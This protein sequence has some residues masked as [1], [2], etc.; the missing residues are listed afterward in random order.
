[1]GDGWEL[2]G[3]AAASA[4]AIR[5]ETARLLVHAFRE[6]DLDAFMAYRNDRAWMRFQ[7]FKGLDVQAYRAALLGTRAVEKG[8]Q[9]AI[10]RRADGVLLGDLYLRREG[11]VIWLGYTVAPAFARAG[12]AAEAAAGALT[13]AKA[14]GCRAA[15]ASVSPENAPSVGLLSKLGFGFAS[16]DAEGD[17]VYERPL[18][19][20]AEPDGPRSVPAP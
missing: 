12:V 8:L 9:L 13:W 20:P 6:D 17:D 3:G 5:F 10:T 18:D 14:A 16:R 19:V 15:R 1:M 7:S 2:R 11:D 4:D